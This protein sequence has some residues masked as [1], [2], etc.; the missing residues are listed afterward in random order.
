MDAYQV[1]AERVK[2]AGSSFYYGMRLLPQEKRSAIY[3]VYAWSRICDDA[4]DDYLGPEAHRQL[5]EAEALYQRAYEEEWRDAPHPVSV[6]LGD[7]IRR[8]HL[9][10][11]A[12]EALV[13]GMRMDLVPRVYQTFAELEQYCLNVAGSIGT[14]CVE[15]FGFTDE[16]ARELAAKLGVALQLTNIIRDMKEDAERG[17]CYLPLEDLERHGVTAQEILTA[18]PTPGL[19]QLL[20]FEA[21]R[22][23]H[24]YHEAM[25]LVNLVEADS[26]RCLRLL[27]G[28]YYLLLQKIEAMGFDV[29]TRRVQVSRRDALKLMGGAFWQVN[30]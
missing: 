6:A 18:R 1:C 25:D 30:G 22:A 11:T 12:F 2:E 20:T 7:A 5:L 27:Y 23:K 3:A 13:E 8:F 10:R 17:R 26:V 9:S 21:E 24:Y 29:W 15:V 4:V 28:I 16:R 14:L 19:I